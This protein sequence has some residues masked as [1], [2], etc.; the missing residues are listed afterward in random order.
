MNRRALLRALAGAGLGLGA[1]GQAAFGQP[2]PHT[3]HNRWAAPP[4]GRGA[5]ASSYARFDD[6]AIETLGPSTVRFDTPPPAGLAGTLYRNGPARMA[7]GAT[8]YRHWFDGDGMIQ[9]LRIHG[10]RLT[11]FGRFVATDRSRAD[12]KAGRFLWSGFGT[13]LAD[14]RSITKPDDL[15]VGNISVLPLHDELLALWEAGSAWRIDPIDLSTRGRKVFSDETD[16]MSFS[17][18]PRIDADGRIWNFGYAGGSGKLFLYDIAPSGQLHRTAVIDAPNADMVHDFAVTADYLVFVLTP[19]LTRSD[20]PRGT[21]SF[22]ERMQWRPDLPAWL[23]VVDKNTLTVHRR[24]ELPNFFAFHLG[25]AWQDGSTLRVDVAR[26]E[27]FDRLMTAIE[28]ASASR[29]IAPFAQMRPMQ[30]SFD[31]NSG[32]SATI[33]DLPLPFA[34]FP[35]YDQRHGGQRTSKLIMLTRNRDVDPHVFGLNAVTVLDRARARVSTFGYGPAVIAEEHVFVAR[36]PDSPESRGWVIGTAFDWRAHR[37]SL[38]I[39]DADAI[40]AGPIATARLPYALPLGLHGQFV[41]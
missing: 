26:T 13:H 5:F 14:S 34:E 37:T 18:H 12:A 2:A 24:C 38:H 11:H 21:E 33:V 41:A 30:V 32:K 8:H 7:R 10:D 40:E 3:G 31:L 23:L 28:R 6:A 29:E 19:V 22:L 35:R 39:F 15:N 9:S 4:D 17:A 25:N 20:Q 36:R 16:G 1:V 27:P